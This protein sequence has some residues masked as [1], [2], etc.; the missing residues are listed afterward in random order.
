MN[1]ACVASA[2]N[3]PLHVAAHFGIEFNQAHAGMITAL[4]SLLSFSSKL[5][6]RRHN[7]H[8]GGDETTASMP[9][10]R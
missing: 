9:S 3:R 5:E 6:C 2:T 7:R 8:S 4:A 1:T 10:C